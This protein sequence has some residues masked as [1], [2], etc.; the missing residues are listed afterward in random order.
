MEFENPYAVQSAGGG[1]GRGDQGGPRLS[2]TILRQIRVIA[3]L[4]IV[5]GLMLMLMGVF[6]IGLAFLF[7]TMMAAQ[8]GAMRQ[9]AGGPPPEQ[10]KIILIVVYGGMG[11]AGLVPGVLQVVA[12]SYNLFAKKRMLGIVALAVGTVS[13]GT[14]Y[15]A[16]TAIALFV[17]GLIIYLHDTSK[18]AFA[19][20]E[21][22]YSWQ[23]IESLAR[24]S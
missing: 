15:C 16:P 4:L 22:G 9:Q 7:P 10:L 12:G 23:E 14:C 18:Q 17:Y 20:Q 3:V 1:P 5:H 11:V 13:V 19:L 2:L 24:Q 21:Q 6:L 8:P